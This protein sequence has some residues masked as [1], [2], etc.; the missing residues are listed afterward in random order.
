MADAY[1]AVMGSDIVVTSGT[2]GADSQASAMYRKLASGENIMSLY[3]NQTAAGQIRDS[4]TAG[5]ATGKNASAIITDMTSVIS[6]Q[7]SNNVYISA[8][9]RAGAVD[10][11]MRGMSTS[12]R[13]AFRAAASGVANTVLKES[14]H[15]HLQF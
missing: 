14:D 3:R 1:N 6:N 9:L 8:H 10:V 5:V 12:Q 15:W 13:S 4:Y 11:R 2:R 7:I